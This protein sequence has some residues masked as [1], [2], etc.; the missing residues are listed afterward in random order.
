MLKMPQPNSFPPIRVERMFREISSHMVNLLRVLQP[1]EW[2]LPTSSSERNVKDVVSHLLDGSL[3]RLSMQRDGYVVPDHSSQKQPDES[4]LEFLNR[5]NSDWDKAT[6]RLSPNVLTGLIEWADG[7][8]ADLFESLDP[9]GP[10]IFQ[11]AWAGEEQSQNWMDVARDYTEKWHHTQ[12]IFDATGRPSTITER[13]LFHPCLDIFFRALPFTFRGVDAKVET[14][15][16]LRITGD[17]ADTWYIERTSNGWQQVIEPTRPVTSTVT[18]DQITAWRLVT[19]RRTREQ[20][21]ARFSDI[22]IEGDT[23][24]GSHILDMVSMMV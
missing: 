20:T 8:L 1:A 7:Q 10:A 23:E 5:L 12:Q 24:L 22:L 17:A 3:R 21:L 19:K 9:F 15:I 4:L 16:A 13:R 18:M 11:V 6:R 14:S 2:H